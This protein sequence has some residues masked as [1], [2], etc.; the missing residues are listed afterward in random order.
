MRFSATQAIK[1]PSTICPECGQ[2]SAV[3]DSRPSDGTVRRRRRCS[4]CSNRWTTIEL[5]QDA[6]TEIEEAMNLIDKKGKILATYKAIK[7]L[8]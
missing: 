8:S 6:I 2:G 7:E 4:H 3:T 5:N 1:L